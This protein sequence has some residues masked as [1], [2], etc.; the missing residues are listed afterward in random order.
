MEALRIQ[1]HKLLQQHVTLDRDREDL[2]A[3]FGGIREFPNE[4]LEHIFVLARNNEA[5][6]TAP[7]THLFV[8]NSLPANGK[9]ARV[10][11]W[12]ICQVSRRWNAVATGYPYLWCFLGLDL[13]E[14]ESFRSLSER[15]RLFAL[16]L[17]RASNVEV[18]LS[19]AVSRIIS[20][21]PWL[22]PSLTRC[23]H[24]QLYTPNNNV[25][26]Q[27]F[28]G[29]KLDLTSLESLQI[30]QSI[31]EHP[32]QIGLPN[33]FLNAPRLTEIIG[34]SYAL[35]QVQLPWNQIKT[36]IIQ[37]ISYRS[38]VAKL[39]DARSSSYL[40]DLWKSIVSSPS[41][42]ELSIQDNVTAMSREWNSEWPD[43]S[44]G[45]HHAFSPQNRREE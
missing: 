26:R 45:F 11:P 13:I 2:R 25:M 15:K 22:L 23:R 34:H 21:D 44:D 35:R 7:S 10:A 32:L 9:A 37:P 17:T 18:H 42:E 20:L 19:L 38:Q 4:I 12:N 30:G 39:D 1:Y 40:N 27:C 8:Q 3:V 29:I 14:S 33:P 43:F 41:I 16:Q 24:L 31:C 36:V 6:Q 5:M 28:D